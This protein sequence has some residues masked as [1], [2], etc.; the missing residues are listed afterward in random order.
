MQVT[1]DD[2]QW[3]VS[4]RTPLMEVLAQ[5]SDKAHAK[6]RIVTSLQ[7][8]ERR[9][10]DRDLTRDL[11]AQIGSEIGRVQATSQSM[12]QVFKG[13]DETLNRYAGL[14]KLDGVALVKALRT[15][16]TPGGLLDAWLGR[17]AD[18][19]EYLEVKRTHSAP[20]YA[21][22]PFAPWVARLLDARLTGDWVGL[23]D[24]LEYE[25]LTRLSG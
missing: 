3:T 8:G 2:E 6:G 22:E 18:Y 17:L 15:G 9:L 23:A 13:A 16:Q 5:V 25:I 7:L 1:L 4:D 14:L 24:V 20:D 12:D 10:T 11:L 19:V 21:V